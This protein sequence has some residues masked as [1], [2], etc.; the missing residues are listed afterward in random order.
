MGI[1]NVVTDQIGNNILTDTASSVSERSFI[2]TWLSILFVVD[3]PLQCIY[4]Y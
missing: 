1:L 3:V 2:H 4:V